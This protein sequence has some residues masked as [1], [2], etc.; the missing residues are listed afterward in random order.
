MDVLASISDFL[1]AGSLDGEPPRCAMANDDPILVDDEYYLGNCAQDGFLVANI[2]HSAIATIRS[3]LGPF[4]RVSLQHGT[5]ISSPYD[6]M[7]PLGPTLVICS[8]FIF[9]VLHTGFYSIP[10]IALPCTLLTQMPTFA[11]VDACTFAHADARTFANADARTFAH[12]D[13]C[14]FAHADARNSA[15]ADARNADALKLLSLLSNAAFLTSK[16]RSEAPTIRD[17]R[18][19]SLR[20]SHS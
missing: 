9:I 20:R 7:T 13:A 8:T 12:A 6:A 4:S 18:F 19:T 10:P 5:L 2:P 16:R 11:H 17:P 15:Q 1:N 3:L 14:T